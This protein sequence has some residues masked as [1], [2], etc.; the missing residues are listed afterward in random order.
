MNHQDQCII[1]KH[2]F[3]I[4]YNTNNNIYEGGSLLYTLLSLHL[5]MLKELY[6]YKCCDEITII[7]FRGDVLS[8]V[9]LYE[10]VCCAYTDS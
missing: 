4:L 7:H 5:H 8:I 2:P 6:I 1:S 3:H 9:H 10:R